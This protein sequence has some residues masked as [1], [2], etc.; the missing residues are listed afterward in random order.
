MRKYISLTLLFSFLW[1]YGCATIFEG[2]KES[3]SLNSEP[4]QASVYINGFKEGTTPAAIRLEKG[5]EYI[6]ESGKRDMRV[7]L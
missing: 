3:I 6:I 5:K 1:Y 2:T 4:N 7:N